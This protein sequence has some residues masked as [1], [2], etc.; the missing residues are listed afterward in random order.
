MRIAFTHN[1]AREADEANA[2]FDSPENVERLT[3]ALRALGHVV[4]PIEVSGS[5]DDTIAA[6]RR[7]GPDLVFNTAEGHHGRM[8]EAVI[9]LVCEQLGLAHT[10]AGAHAMAVTLDKQLTKLVV[11]AHGVRVP[12]GQ[13][14]TDVAAL[15]TAALRFPVIVKPNFEGSSKGITLDS[16]VDDE[17]ALRQRVAATLER[18]GIGVLVEEFVAGHDVAVPFLEA[19]GGARGGVLDPVEYGI[20][21]VPRA[22]GRIV[23]DLDLTGSGSERVS[24]HAPATLSDAASATVLEYSRRAVRALDLHDLGRLDFRIAL[25]GTVYFLEANALPSLEAGAGLFAAAALAGLDTLEQV[26]A[27]VIDSAT[28]RWALREPAPEDAGALRVGFTYNQKRVKPDLKGEHDQEAEYESPELLDAIRSALRELGHEVV[29]LEATR[30]LPGRLATARVD[31]VFNLA[32]GAHGRGREAHV[33]SMLEWL[34]I[35]FTGT[36]AVGMAL[37]L[38]K[39]LAKQ[40]VAGAG[41]PV[42]RGLVLDSVESRVEPGAVTFPAIVK[43]LAEGSSKGVLGTSVVHDL[44]ALHATAA[45]II[46]KYRGAAL[47]EEFLPGREFSVGVLGY[48]VPEVLPVMEMRFLPAAGAFPVYGFENKQ[49]YNDA[50]AFE[51][52]ASLDDARTQE[53]GALALCAY[54]ALGCRDLARLDF[55]MDAAGRFHFIECNPLPGLTPNWSDF[56]V[57]GRTAGLDFTSLIGE[58]L[59]GALRRRGR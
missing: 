28:R 13:F 48:P 2:E 17:A 58:I 27:A 9:P 18:Y 20:D 46:R 34:G 7:F 16:V 43:P 44:E 12:R 29:D 31:V 47:V 57:M 15:D 11:S 59:A 6:L 33:P 51:C 38:D 42:P 5:L 21:G 56:A 50:M 37:T 22:P 14:V 1:L 3:G 36:D 25:D 53:L 52:P 45:A 19:V 54:R 10:G 30:D 55:R 32:E 40:V 4:E 8:R 24:V 23:Y 49:Q 39:A 41:V 26:V 35:P